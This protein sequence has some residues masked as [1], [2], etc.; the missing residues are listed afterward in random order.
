MILKEANQLIKQDADK[1]QLHLVPPSII[2]G[3]ARVR[4]YGVKKYGDS[5]NWRDVKPIRY[6]DAAFRHLLKIIMSGIKAVDEESGL[7]HLWHLACNVAFLCERLEEKRRK[8]E[9]KYIC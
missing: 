1:P 5:E 4:E 8:K 6:V 2:I 7:P 9:G 3:I